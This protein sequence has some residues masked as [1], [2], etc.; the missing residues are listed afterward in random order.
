MAEKTKYEGSEAVRAYIR[1]AILAEPGA[2]MAMAE[3][4]ALR[5][6]R[7]LDHLVKLASTEP[8]L[9]AA[10]DFDPFAFGAVVT[11]QR[12]G[13]ETLKRRLEKIESV[14]HLRHMAEAQHLAAD[15]SLKDAASLRRA[16]IAG[17]EMR[18]ANRCAAAAA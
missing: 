15:V 1:E 5:L 13:R 14:E 2:D 4:L 6:S 3:R 9:A 18:L 16:I 11:L 10:P 17:A 7:D 8:A 12:D